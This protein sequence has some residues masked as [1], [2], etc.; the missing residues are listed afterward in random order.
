M[1]FHA[2]EA[3]EGAEGAIASHVTTREPERVFD[4][5][6]ATLGITTTDSAM[7]SDG[8]RYRLSRMLKAAAARSAGL[9]KRPRSITT[10]APARSELFS[11]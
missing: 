8:T 11:A 7:A 2:I 1:S 3:P 9:M 6:T 4:A 10:T 5:Y